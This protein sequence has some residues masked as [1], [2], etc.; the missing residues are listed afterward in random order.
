M[1]FAVPDDHRIKLKE[2]EKEYKYVFFVRKLKK[3]M[4]HEKWK[5][6]WNMK[7]MIIS[8]VIGAFGTVTKGLI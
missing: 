5:K 2:S 6:L 1:D 7:V 4:E 8:I 3:T